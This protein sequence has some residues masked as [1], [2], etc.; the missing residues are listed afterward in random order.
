MST[1][2]AS[3]TLDLDLLLKQGAGATINLTVVDAAGQPITDPTGYIVRAHIR[4]SLWSPPEFVWDSD[5]GPGAAE[6][7]YTPGPPEVSHTVLTLTGA[8]T[9]GFIFR[10]ALWDCFLLAPGQEPACLAAGSIHVDPYI[11]RGG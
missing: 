11:T 7:I 10:D 1:V 8:Q 4:R 3:K 2:L 6:I 5:T 9:A